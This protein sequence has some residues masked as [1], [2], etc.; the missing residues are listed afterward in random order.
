MPSP[1]RLFRAPVVL[2][3]ALAVGGCDMSLGHLAGRAADEWSRSYPLTAG[4]EVRIANTNGRIDIEGVDGSTVEVQAERIAKAA[5]DEGA[6]ELLP[7]IVIRED[8]R[9]DRVS[10]ETERLSGIMIGAAYEVRYHVRAPKNA[11]ID[12]ANTNGAVLVNGLAGS[13]TVHTTNGSVTTKN[14]TGAVDARTT[15]GSVNVDVAAVGAERIALRTTNGSVTLN[16]PDTAKADVSAS[17]TNG[18]INVSDSVKIDVSERG[19]RRFEGRMNGGG[20]PVELRTTN[21]G[22]R[23]RSRAEAADSKTAPA[24]S[25]GPGGGGSDAHPDRPEKT[26]KELRSRR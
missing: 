17:W 1:T 20:A 21:G 26:L 4:G 2:A 9:P 23:I 8:I 16:L 19:R 3:V 18:G 22:I 24:T 15:N 7:R 6:R 10:I 25:E 14:L 5:T 12:A 13:V 11:V